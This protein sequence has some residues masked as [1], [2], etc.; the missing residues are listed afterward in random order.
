MVQQI[1]ARWDYAIW[2]NYALHDLSDSEPASG[3]Q[4]IKKIN[5]LKKI[6]FKWLMF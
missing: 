4:K 1:S 3:I 5:D 6:K 2:D